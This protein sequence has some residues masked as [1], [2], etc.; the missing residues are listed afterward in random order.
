MK[1]RGGHLACPTDDEALL[2][3][4]VA[5][6]SMYMLAKYYDR[7]CGLNGWLT[8]RHSCFGDQKGRWERNA[9][10]DA[11]PGLSKM[12]LLVDQPSSP[13]WYSLATVHSHASVCTCTGACTAETQRDKVNS[14]RTRHC[15]NCQTPSPDTPD[16]PD[17]TEQYTNPRRPPPDVS[18]A[19]HGSPWIA[20]DM[21]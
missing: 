17:T 10:S 4:I 18:V 20:F 9:R 14:N 8:D 5:V 21:G 11:R 3:K 1:K 2:I 15:L 7:R 16:T 13:S 19:Y 6:V 12:R